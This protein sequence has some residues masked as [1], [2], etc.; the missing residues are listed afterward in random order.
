MKQNK[1]QGNN[2]RD[3]GITYIM[4]FILYEMSSVLGTFAI[5]SKDCENTFIDC[6]LADWTVLFVTVSYLISRVF[7]LPCVLE[8]GRTRLL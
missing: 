2:M 1:E 3:L 8:V 4:A 6:Y 7:F 5:S